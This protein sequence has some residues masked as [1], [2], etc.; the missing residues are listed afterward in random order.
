MYL[1][2]IAISWCSSNPLSRRAYESGRPAAVLLVNR[3][4][5]IGAVAGTMLRGLNKRCLCQGAYLTTRVSQQ[6]CDLIVEFARR[7]IEHG[8]ASLMAQRSARQELRPIL[9][10]P[11]A[12]SSGYCPPGVASGAGRGSKSRGTGVAGGMITAKRCDLPRAGIFSSQCDLVHRAGA[13]PRGGATNAPA[14]AE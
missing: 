9:M 3:R 2:G 5:S 12:S 13:G 7:I 11:L 14:A 1:Y 4:E 8:E 6:E 10:T